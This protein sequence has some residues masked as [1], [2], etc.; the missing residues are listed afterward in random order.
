M[1]DFNE[2]KLEISERMTNLLLLCAIRNVF[3]SFFSRVVLCVLRVLKI[4]EKK[5]K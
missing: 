5:R 2:L 4:Q 3:R 1:T